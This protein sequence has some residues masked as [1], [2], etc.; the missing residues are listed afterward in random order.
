[1]L[2]A[3]SIP[4]LHCGW[5]SMQKNNPMT[6][7]GIKP[8]IF[9]LVAQCLN[10]LCHSVLVPSKAYCVLFPPAGTIAAT[11]Q[12]FDD[13]RGICPCILHITFFDETYPRLLT[14]DIT[15][16]QQRHGLAHGSLHCVMSTLLHD[17]VSFLKR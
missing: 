16:N 6:S 14:S 11:N 8:E 4:R 17:N 12:Y 3:E 7:A 5:K 13:A 2:G 9:R 15:L 1:M 10:Q